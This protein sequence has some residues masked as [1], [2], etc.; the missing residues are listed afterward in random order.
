MLN[1]GKVYL[2]RKKLKYSFLLF[3]KETIGIN[4]YLKLKKL[5]SEL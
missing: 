2:Y 4:N 5:V 1:P 3:L